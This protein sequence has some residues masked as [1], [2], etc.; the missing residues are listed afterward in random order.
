MCV[1]GNLMYT[2]SS[3][4]FMFPLHLFCLEILSL[5]CFHQIFNYVLLHSIK[6]WRMQMPC[7][8]RPIFGLICCQ[9]PQNVPAVNHGCLSGFEA[10]CLAYTLIFLVLQMSISKLAHCMALLTWAHSETS[11]N[12]SHSAWSTW[13]IWQNL[14]I[15]RRVFEYVYLKLGMMFDNVI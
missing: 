6:Q 1:T 2:Q 12:S 4:H 10:S 5:V 9:Y 7:A 11:E 14:S 13:A 15:V 3:D 8:A